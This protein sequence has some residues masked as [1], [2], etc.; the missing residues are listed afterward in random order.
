MSGPLK[1][2][3]AIFPIQPDALE[4]MVEF[5]T[6]ARDAGVRRLWLGQ[7]LRVET[8]LA[9][10]AF[11][12]RVPGV[13]LGTSVALAM[14]R[15]PYQAAVEARSIS[16]L[17]GAPY[18]AGFGPGAVSF[19]KQFLG[20]PYAKPLR[21]MTE[22]VSVVRRLLDSE[23]L[24]HEGEY[25]TSTSAML[26][27]PAPAIEV[28]L[29][30]LRPG[31]AR[32]VG[33][34]ADVAI[35]WL[36]PH[37]YINEQLMPAIEQGARSAERTG[38]PRVASIVHAAVDRPGR[39]LR[40]LVFAAAG[41]HLGSEHYTDMLKRAGLSV[42][43]RDPLKGAEELIRE[44]V[45]ATGT[46]EDIAKVVRAHREAGVDEVVVNVCGVYLMEGPQ[47]AAKDLR[48]ILEAVAADD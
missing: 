26:H 46:A 48:E 40:R 47:A 1:H 24:S 14:L 39:N 10:A 41:P 31:M 18:V 44:Q 3:S 7:S 5:G 28:G 13:S 6:F 33:E 38:V 4:P 29:G 23:K 8:H 2:T 34:V 43:P 12:A 21:A 15:H 16:T 22:Y 25:F 19:Q 32:T 11:A 27:V 45:F 37:W 42:D 30:V 17:S 35:T 9:L 20:E 36:T